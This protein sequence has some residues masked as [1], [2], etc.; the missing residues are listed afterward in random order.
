M[1]NVK[2]SNSA[3]RAPVADVA[4]GGSDDSADATCEQAKYGIR[5]TVNCRLDASA[6]S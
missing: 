6:A 5:A 2:N 3:A 1:K 4:A